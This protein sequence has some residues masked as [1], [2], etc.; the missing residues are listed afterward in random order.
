MKE[1]RICDLEMRATGHF[2]WLLERLR[3]AHH[4]RGG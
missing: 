2:E 1:V 3:L 4:M